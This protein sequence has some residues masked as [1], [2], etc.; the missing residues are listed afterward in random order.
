MVSGASGRSWDPLGV[1]EKQTPR[2]VAESR[3]WMR[4]VLAD[5]PAVLLG[6]AEYR[7]WLWHVCSS[8]RQ[9]LQGLDGL[10]KAQEL[11]PDLS[12]ENLRQEGWHGVPYL[13]LY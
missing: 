5:Q 8:S 1:R 2:P 4:R 11:R 13:P 6:H 10:S 9:K 12:T 3:P 7:R